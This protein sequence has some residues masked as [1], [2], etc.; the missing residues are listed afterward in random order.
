MTLRFE[1]SIFQFPAL[2]PERRNSVTAES[3]HRQP[4]NQGEFRCPIIRN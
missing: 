1:I 3:R 2:T 4:G